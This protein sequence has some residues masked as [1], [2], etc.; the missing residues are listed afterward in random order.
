MDEIIHII[1]ISFYNSIAV[2]K[3][4]VDTINVSSLPLFPF[5]I[6]NSSF[7][8]DK[9]FLSP[10]SILRSSQLNI[11]SAPLNIR[12]ALLNIYSA[13]WNIKFLVENLEI[14]YRVSNFAAL[15]KKKFIISIHSGD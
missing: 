6:I 13:V 2:L 1:G 5:S 14:C 4:R 15:S 8:H 7:L 12:S 3:V 11:Y 10:H 9:F